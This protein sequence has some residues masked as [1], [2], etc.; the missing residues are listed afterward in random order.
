[1]RRNW[2]QANPPSG[3]GKPAPQITSYTPTTGPA[4]GGTTVTFT[5]KHF[6][7]YGASGTAITFGGTS[8]GSI[9]VISDTS[10]TCTT[11]AKAAG[12]YDIVFANSNGTWT[13][14]NGF[15]YT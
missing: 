10:T 1:M 11:P 12:T 15:V 13:I 6:S 5:G 3:T 7:N 9:T 14:P 8:G 2:S 4:A